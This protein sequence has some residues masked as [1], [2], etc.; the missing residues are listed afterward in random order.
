MNEAHF[1][2]TLRRLAKSGSQS[3]QVI[4]TSAASDRDLNG[5][6]QGAAARQ[7]D[8]GSQRLLRPETPDLANV[9][10]RAAQSRG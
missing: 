7:V 6:L 9:I 3:E 10:E 5:M 8:L 1:R 4:V 2:E